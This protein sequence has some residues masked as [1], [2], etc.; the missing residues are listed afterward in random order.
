MPYR[1]PLFLSFCLALCASS[2]ARAEEKPKPSERLRELG[3]CGK[4]EQLGSFQPP[5]DAAYKKQLDAVIAQTGKKLGAERKKQLDALTAPQTAESVAYI[6]IGLAMQKSGTAAVYVGALGARKDINDAHA[7]STV[8]VL[9]DRTGNASAAHVTLLRARALAPKSQIAASNLGWLYVNAGHIDRAQTVFESF[10]SE[11]ENVLAPVALGMA[12]TLGCGND[13]KAEDWVY[14]ALGHGLSRGALAVMQAFAPDPPGLDVVPGM[15]VELVDPVLEEDPETVTKNLNR[16]YALAG[17]TQRQMIEATQQ[18]QTAVME[19]LALP[20]QNDNFDLAFDLFHYANDRFEDEEPF[21]KL[22]ADVEKTV[23]P[24]KKRIAAVHQEAL[25]KEAAC[26]N[27]SACIKQ[28]RQEDCRKR[29]EAAASAHGEFYRLFWDYW[30][31]ER[32]RVE[33]YYAHT[34]PLAKRQRT[35]NDVKKWS[36]KVNVNTYEVQMN[37]HR[38][39]LA[40]QIYAMGHLSEDC[41]MITGP[42]MPPPSLAQLL[43]AEGEGACKGMEGIKVQIPLVQTMLG[44]GLDVTI[45]CGKL[46]AEATF[47]YVGKLSLGKDFLKGEYTVFAGAQKAGVKGGVYTVFDE[48]GVSDVG[49]E[50]GFSVKDFGATKKLSIMNGF[51]VKD[52]QWSKT[53]K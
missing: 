27:N 13:P 22:E 36:A 18:F 47:R 37:A 11:K 16:C 48:N 35:P 33:D 39:A 31:A 8:G 50:G 2:L 17:A 1:L 20:Q 46:E 23:G 32:K 34:M 49:L 53:F 45:E 51:E 38:T 12:V 41:S 52:T 3:F 28:A 40:W 25:K 44:D 4:P 26:K 7:A 6:A 9:L 15:T 43:A 42:E 14:T 30:R 19:M 29:H 10:S 21:K 24:Y 5:S